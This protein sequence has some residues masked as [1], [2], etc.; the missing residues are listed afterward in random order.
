MKALYSFMKNILTSE[1]LSL[2][3][4]VYMAWIF[5]QAG[6][7][8][9]PDPALFAENVADYRIIP[10]FAVNLVALVLP[11][12]E[13]ICAFFLFFGLRTK[14]TATILSGLLVMFTFFVIVNIFRGVSMN[15]GCFDNVGEPIGW[16]KVTQNTIW[17]LMTVQIYFFDRINFFRGSGYPGKKKTPEIAAVSSS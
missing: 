12:M 3:L 5:L 6:L 13:L 15:C 4:R 2:A 10:H 16:T 14:A 1:Y 11:W 8:K 9:I 17:L 7:G